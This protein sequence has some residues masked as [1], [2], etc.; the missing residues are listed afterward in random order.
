MLRTPILRVGRRHSSSVAALAYKALHRQKKSPLP[1][2]DTPNWSAQSAV[3]SILYETPLPSKLPKKQHVL[4]CLVQNEPGVLSL[5]S[6]ILAGRGFNIDSLVVCNTD[7]KDLSRMTIVLKGHDGVIEQ[8]RKQIED[9]VPVFAVLDYSHADIIQRELLMARV[10]LLGPEFFQD[11]LR[12]HE[13]SEESLADFD[14]TYHPKNLSPSEL[15]RIKNQYLTA[16]QNLTSQFGGRI[17]DVSA[18]NCIIELSGKPARI[19]NFLKLINPFGVLEV[20][21][22]GLMAMPRTPLEDVKEEVVEEEEAV[23][24]TELPPG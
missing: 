9:V 17:V 4:N 7:V 2:L 5:I 19:T 6:G 22:S 15:L 20:A 14:E 12:Q 13:G 16:L 3:N 23:D 1:T 8:A 18:K 21:R 11:L 24:L 10:S